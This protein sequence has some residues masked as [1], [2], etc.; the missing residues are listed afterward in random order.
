MVAVVAVVIIV[1]DDDE[2]IAN[3]SLPFEPIYV[4]NKN[5]KNEINREKKKNYFLSLR[6]CSFGSIIIF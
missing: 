6:R 1:D 5:G 3:G 4:S 2:P